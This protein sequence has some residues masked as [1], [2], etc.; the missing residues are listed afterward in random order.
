MLVNSCYFWLAKFTSSDW[1]I[2]GA[3]TYGTDLLDL[4]SFSFASPL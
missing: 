3:I 4:L 1:S 2:P